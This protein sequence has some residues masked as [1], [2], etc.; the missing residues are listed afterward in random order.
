MSKGHARLHGSSLDAAFGWWGG[1]FKVT[2]AVC[3]VMGEVVRTSCEAPRAPRAAPIA[4]CPGW[5]ECARATWSVV[6]G[7]CGS[8]HLVTVHPLRL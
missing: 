2:L 8:A 4:S 6:E 7:L 3:N 1:R 5:K